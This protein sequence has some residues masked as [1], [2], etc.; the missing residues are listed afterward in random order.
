VLN[1]Y[2]LFLLLQNFTEAYDLNVD[3][4]QLNNLATSLNPAIENKYMSWLEHLKFCSGLSCQL[5]DVRNSP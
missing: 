4:Y 5:Q 3:P 1:Y 2:N